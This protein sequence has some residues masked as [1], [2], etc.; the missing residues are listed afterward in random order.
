M[1]SQPLSRKQA[2]QPKSV[3]LLISTDS[4]GVAEVLC[5]GKVYTFRVDAALLHR[6]RWKWEREPWRCFNILR[7]R[8]IL[9]ENR[10]R[11]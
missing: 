3:P 10:Q 4:L 8:N 7:S 2:D 11:K 5:R 6:L 1:T 9:K